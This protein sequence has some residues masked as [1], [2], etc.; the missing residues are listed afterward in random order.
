MTVTRFFQIAVAT[1]LVSSPSLFAQAPAATAQAG[2]A[3]LV[4]FA[5]TGDCKGAMQYAR[6]PYNAALDGSH[7]GD[8]AQM[9]N[10][11]A[12]ICLNAG[13]TASAEEW[14]RMSYAAG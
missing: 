12:E 1:I 13:D 3:K 11:V 4:S 7:F 8:A 14:A 6:G 2:Q 10:D 5:S 9:A